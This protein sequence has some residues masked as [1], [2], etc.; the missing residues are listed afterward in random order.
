MTTEIRDA[1]EF[2]RC[3]MK[4]AKRNRDDFG[5]VDTPE[6]LARLRDT[7][8]DVG[9]AVA[10]FPG[11]Q[12]RWDYDILKGEA[13]MRQCVETGVPMK[14]PV[15]AVLCQTLGELHSVYS[16]LNITREATAH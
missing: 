15:M 14:A 11:E 16:A 7:L 1:K 8:P 12:G 3:L 5:P 9:I 4:I 2:R 13:E 10:F 6:N